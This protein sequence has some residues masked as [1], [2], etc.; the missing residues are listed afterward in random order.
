MKIIYT[1][2]GEGIGHAARSKAV[3][4]HIFAD[5]EI[6]ILAGHRAYEY[7]KRHYAHV[8]RIASFRI[9]YW[10]NRV[11]SIGTFFLNL[12]FFPQIIF[13]LVRT[14]LLIKKFKP[15]IIIDDFS[16][17]GGYAALFTK[18]HMVTIDNQ[19]IITNTQQEEKKFLLDRLKSRIVIKWF[20]PRAD[21]HL[22]TTF[23]NPKIIKNNAILIP[24]LLRNEIL[25]L[26]PRKGGYVFLYQT[27][28]TNKKLL[29]ILKSLNVPCIVYGFDKSE[30][31]GSLIFKRS[32]QQSF[33]EDL[34]NSK[35]I[36][37]NGGFTLITEALYLKKPILAF[38]V[39]H[40]YEQILNA[41]ELKKLGYGEYY[42]KPSAEVIKTF[43]S[44]LS[45]YEENLHRLTFDYQKPFRVIDAALK[46]TLK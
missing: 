40:Q 38:P 25:D 44:K 16:W 35:A 7:L 5:H 45:I 2:C 24:P 8:Q 10:R 20:V 22:I 43:M 29:Q 18:T 13:S 17:V 4:D 14:I 11:T 36:V 32:F 19:H 23:F 37:L 1:I 28:K 27:S 26:H 6:Q 30:T 21:K 39:S 3:L 34:A 33:Y 15:D 41:M 31:D 9:A 42:L 12:Y 46:D